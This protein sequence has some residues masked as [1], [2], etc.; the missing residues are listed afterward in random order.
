MEHRIE[1]A[2]APVAELIDGTVVK[3][4]V[5]EAHQLV[6]SYAAEAS[7]IKV[8]AAGFA[9]QVVPRQARAQPSRAAR[10]T[11]NFFAPRA[12]KASP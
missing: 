7:D 3:V 2:L 12:G 11:P 10:R 1:P 5:E 9:G 8:V 4:A 6:A